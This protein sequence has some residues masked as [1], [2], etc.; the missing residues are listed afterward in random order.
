[1]SPKLAVLPGDGVGPEVTAAALSVLQAVLPVEIREG[2]VGGAAIDKEGDPLPKATLELC[3]S[4]HAVFLGAVGGPKWD[5]GPA[6]PEDGLLRLRRGLGLYANLRPARYLGLP[7]PLKDGLARHADIMVVRELAGG[8]YF[9]EPRSASPDVAINT[10]RQTADEVRAVAHVAFRLARRRRGLVTSVDKANVLEASRLWRRVVSEVAREYAD[11]NLEHRYVDA[12]AFE[13]LRAPQHF[14]VVLTENLFGDILSDEA[15]AVAGSIGVLPSASLGPG[16]GLFEPVHGAA[17]DIAGR[18]IA[19]P[20]GALLTVA[21]MLEHAFGQPT[22]ARVVERSVQ[23]AL[24]EVRTPDV[25]G[26]ATTAQFTAAVH[27]HLS[28]TRWSDETDEEV[29]RAAEWGV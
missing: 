13:L 22:L 21:L 12:T 1:M 2:L 28:W 19:N 20:T 11:V 7:T 16:P 15:A 25:G 26:G 10:W 23:A 24:R 9:G 5:G 29:P 18:G 6:R 17:P 27:R 14:D 8:V 4:S 3:A